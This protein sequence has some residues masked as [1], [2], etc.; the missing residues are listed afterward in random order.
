MFRAF[1]LD[2]PGT[3]RLV[4]C[5]DN[6]TEYTYLMRHSRVTYQVHKLAVLGRVMFAGCAHAQ[7][8]TELEDLAFTALTAPG[9][10]HEF[11]RMAVLAL[12]FRCD[13]GNGLTPCPHGCHLRTAGAHAVSLGMTRVCDDCGVVYWTALGHSC[14][15]RKGIAQGS[16]PPTAA[17]PALTD[18]GVTDGRPDA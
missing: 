5:E 13:H 6:T 16:E 4:V 3:G 9:P 17:F 8:R 12:P 14:A 2:G 10:D 18:Q 7:T 11:A 15:P 1:L